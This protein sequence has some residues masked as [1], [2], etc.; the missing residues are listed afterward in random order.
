MIY[1]I[2]WKI[3][4]ED[5]LTAIWLSG[6]DRQYLREAVDAFERD[7]QVN[8]LSLGES[9]EGNFRLVFVG[10]LRIWI[11][12]DTDAKVVTVYNI[13]RVNNRL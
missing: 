3:N 8:P 9:R 4:A 2:D 13:V 1:Q 12:V 7:C 6:R 5:Q 11:E 10:P